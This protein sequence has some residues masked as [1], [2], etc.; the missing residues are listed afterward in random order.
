[1]FA[2]F[3]PAQERGSDHL[4]ELTGRHAVRGAGSQQLKIRPRQESPRLEN[5]RGSDGPSLHDDGFTFVRLDPLDGRAD[6]TPKSRVRSTI[7]LQACG[8]SEKP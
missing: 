6:G 2:A 4:V 5:T 7:S 8:S 1:M 3:E